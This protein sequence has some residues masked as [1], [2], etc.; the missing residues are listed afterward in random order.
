MPT[1]QIKSEL[2][3]WILSE[4]NLVLQRV[5]GHLN[6]YVL[7]L[8]VKEIDNFIDKF[9][10]WYLRRSRRRFWASGM[11]EDKKGAY[12]TLSYVFEG[13]LKVMAPYAPFMTEKI[14]LEAKKAGLMRGEESIHL[15]GFP[16]AF[17]HYIDQK[18]MEE[19]NL[20]RKIVKLGLYL[21]SKN[22]IK[23]KQPLQKLYIKLE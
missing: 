23:V 17:A 13:L 2:D 1:Q 6:K 9:T 5:E 21:R 16:L 8:P 12:W 10:N 18:L 3:K 19:I 7:D 20:V 22:K 4:F 15:E 14:W 11:D